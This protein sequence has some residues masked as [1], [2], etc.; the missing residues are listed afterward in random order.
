MRVPVWKNVMALASA[1]PDC[2]I[3]SSR[4][5]YKARSGAGQNCN[6]FVRSAARQWLASHKPRI[7]GWLATNWWSV[8][9]VLVEKPFKF[10]I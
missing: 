2:L 5:D 6:V 10:N 9:K 8:N 3:S 4:A 1:R 7:R